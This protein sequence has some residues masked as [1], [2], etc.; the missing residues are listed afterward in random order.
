VVHEHMR[1]EDE[2]NSPDWESGDG[3]VV[4]VEKGRCPPLRWLS[5]RP[6]RDH[7]LWSGGTCGG[8][9]KLSWAR[10]SVDRTVGCIGPDINLLA[11]AQGYFIF[12]LAIEL[13]KCM[14]AFYL[15]I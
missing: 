14:Y 1:E 15:T 10:Q 13:V 3:G 9:R 11:Q 5:A 8:L 2:A 6:E 12:I 7:A 4:G